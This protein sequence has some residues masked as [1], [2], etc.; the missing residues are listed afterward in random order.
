MADSLRRVWVHLV[1]TTWDRQPLLLADVRDEVF[2]LIARQARR[3]GCPV[4]VVG[5]TED[6][7]HVLLT[8][9]ATVSVAELARQCKGA[10][11]RFANKAGTSPIR[12]QGGY[13]AFSVGES[14]FAAV[15]SYI[16]HQQQHH[17]H[18]TFDQRMEPTNPNERTTST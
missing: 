8:L 4:V 6:H 11:A 17:A 12:W 5:G 13:G 9:P 7:V 1:W 14:E 3:K 18:G 2:A 15:R 10:T 16:E